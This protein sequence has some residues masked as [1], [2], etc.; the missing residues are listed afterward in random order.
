MC[1]RFVVVVAFVVVMPSVVCAQLSPSVSEG[2]E[3][4]NSA[5][6]TDVGTSDENT[7]TDTELPAETPPHVAEANERI[8]RGERLFAQGDYDAALS[9][10]EQAYEVIGDHPA[11][12][13]V[14]YNIARAHERRFRYDLAL[15]YYRRYL[16]EGGP[17]APRRSAVESAL[18]TLE[19]LLATVRVRINVPEAEVWL[20]DRQVGTVPGDVVLPAGRHALEFRAEGHQTGRVEVQLAPGTEQTLELTLE[21]LAEEF[22]GIAPTF[23]WTATTA[24]AV[25]AVLGAGFG[26]AALVR[27]RRIDDRLDDPATRIRVGQDDRDAIQTRARVADVLFGAAVLFGATALV[28][29]FRTDWGDESDDGVALRLRLGGSGADLEVRW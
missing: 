3:Q 8:E 2:D 9:E 7:T 5:A 4:T 12:F 19:G 16:D 21:P 27:R 23:F 25:T 20:Q 14:L 24:A 10:F 6:Q 11:R 15:R 26:V 18:Q 29:A 17:D 22:R 1:T 13:L 28:F